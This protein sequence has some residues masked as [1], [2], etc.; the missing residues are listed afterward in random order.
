MKVGNLYV[1]NVAYGFDDESD[2]FVL[3]HLENKPPTKGENRDWLPIG[4]FRNLSTGESLKI[5]HPQSVFVPING[6]DSNDIAETQKN[7]L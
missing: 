2:V 6:L 7:N 3:T 5:N 1:V 4:F